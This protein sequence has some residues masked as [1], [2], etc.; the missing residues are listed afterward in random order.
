MAMV[1]ALGATACDDHA[2]ETPPPNIDISISPATIEQGG[3]LTLT[4]ET[5]NFELVDVSGE[6]HDALKS[7]PQSEGHGDGGAVPRGHYHVYVDSTDETPILMSGAHTVDLVIDAT[8]GSHELIVRLQD[9]SHRIIEPEVL[10]SAPFSVTAGNQGGGG[11]GAG[12]MGAGG[13]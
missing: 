3:T 11:M 7:S 2:E 5:T 9:L 12:G 4:V 6:H 13:N 8:V 1:L 10:D